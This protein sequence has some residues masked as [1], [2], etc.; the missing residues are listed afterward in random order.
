VNG[1]SP[2]GIMISFGF[3]IIGIS[4]RPS[5]K[6]LDTSSA[7]KPSSIIFFDMSVFTFLLLKR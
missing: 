5:K 4:K 7:L 3:S 1:I 2:E 6:A